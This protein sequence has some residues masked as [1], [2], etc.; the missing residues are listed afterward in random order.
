MAEQTGCYTEGEGRRR[1]RC[2]ANLADKC[3]PGWGP[4]RVEH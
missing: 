4:V 1:S 3:D 2:V